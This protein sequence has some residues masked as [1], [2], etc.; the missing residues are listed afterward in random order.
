MSLY[1]VL[2]ERPLFETFNGDQDDIIADIINT[3]GRPPARWWDKWENQHEFFNP[4]GCW[5][6]NLERI[7]TPVSR[8]LH[9]RMWDM[10]RGMTPETCEWDV[11][12]GEMHALE[13]LLRSMLAYE[14][15]E[16][17]TA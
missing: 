7:Y 4:D 14:P 15:L 6:H 13:K 8:P 17:P 11:E 9:Q 2:G 10:G 12:G 16:R 1:E 5:I 3:L